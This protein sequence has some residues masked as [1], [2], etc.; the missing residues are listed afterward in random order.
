M[1]N[2]SCRILHETKCLQQREHRTS[3]SSGR[4]FWSIH[5]WWWCCCWCCGLVWLL[6]FSTPGP[7]DAGPPEISLFS[8][9]R[10]NFHSFFPLLGFS[11]NFGGVLKTG[12]KE[13]PT[14]CLQCPFQDGGEA[15]IR[16]AR[17]LPVDWRCKVCTT[18][19]ALEV[20]G[21]EEELATALARNSWMKLACSQDA[22]QLCQQTIA[23]LFCDANETCPEV[24]VNSKYVDDLS[25][26]G[27]VA[28]LDPGKS[29]LI[30][31]Q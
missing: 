17:V 31:E 11:W 18:M 30:V 6:L 5:F 25:C 19:V 22:L 4:Q 29:I 28:D 10:H 12:T 26:E 20:T 14:P 7:P 2:D 24:E 13:D 21:K 16:T 27:F 8:L 15:E 23:T 9:S 3:A 1:C